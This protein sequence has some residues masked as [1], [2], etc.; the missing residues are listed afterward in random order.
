[1]C[2][3]TFEGH[4]D[5]LTSVAMSSDGSHIVSG[6]WDET[7]KLWSATSGECVKTLEGPP[8]TTYR[9]TVEHTDDLYFPDLFYNVK[10]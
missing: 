4:S 2:V 5:E 9:S 3:K 10:H 8:P 7:V 6:S 1:M